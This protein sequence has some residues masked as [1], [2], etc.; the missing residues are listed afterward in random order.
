MPQASRIDA[1]PGEDATLGTVTEIAQGAPTMRTQFTDF[2]DTILPSTYTQKELK[3]L[4]MINDMNKM[5]GLPKEYIRLPLMN[6]KEMKTAE[7][8]PKEQPIMPYGHV[9]EDELKDQITT[10]KAKSIFN[11]SRGSYHPIASRNGL[12]SIPHKKDALFIPYQSPSFPRFG[13]PCPKKPCH[14]FVDSKS[15]D[16]P[17]QL[18]KMYRDTLRAD[19]DGEIVLMPRYTGTFSGVVTNAGV[20]WGYGNAAV[21]SGGKRIVHISAPSNMKVVKK[22]LVRDWA[23]YGGIKL[24][25]PDVP[26]LEVVEHNRDV[27]C[28]QV[29]N[30]PELPSV[31]HYIPKKMVVR[32]IIELDLLRSQPDLLEWGANFKALS[33]NCKESGLVLH[34]KNGSLSSHYAI[35]AVMHDIPVWTGEIDLVVGQILNECYIEKMKWTNENKELFQNWIRYWDQKPLTDFFEQIRNVYREE[36]EHGKDYAYN[37]G[38]ARY[39]VAT[40]VATIHASLFWDDRPLYIALRAF[41][42]VALSKFVVAA[43][44]GELRHWNV[45]GPGNTLGENAQFNWEDLKPYRKNLDSRSAIY[46]NALDMPLKTLEGWSKTL[47]SDFKNRGWQVEENSYGGPKWADCARTARNT[48]KAINSGM[49]WNSV[50]SR[51]NIMLNTVHNG[52]RILTKWID[53]IHMDVIAEAP[54]MGFMNMFAGILATEWSDEEGIK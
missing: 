16:G 29:R 26:Y 38:A 30:G 14:G 36:S 47:I 31:P 45:S 22:W 8:W 20:T 7:K 9:D 10:D 15:I 41:A 32:E 3:L 46:H 34:L 13:R 42:A 5:L 25:F 23:A 40:A 50:H 18:F 19:K 17:V 48:I 11:L 54:A 28:V 12:V 37:A 39:M 51:S 52:G 49:A 21:T 1:L 35:H 24:S 43:C 2:N 53:D 44:I 27:L 6:I 33:K 4:T